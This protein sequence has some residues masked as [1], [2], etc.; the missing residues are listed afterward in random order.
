MNTTN[1]N[2]RTHACTHALWCTIIYQEAEPSHAQTSK[3]TGTHK[4][5]HTYKKGTHTEV[6]IK[7]LMTNQWLNKL[8]LKLFQYW[9]RNA[10]AVII[11]QAA[12]KSFGAFHTLGRNTNF[13]LIRSIGSCFQP[14][15]AQGVVLQEGKCGRKSVG[16]VGV[17]RRVWSDGLQKV[18]YLK[19]WLGERHHNKN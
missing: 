7:S 13:Y 9:A 18:C 15:L 16:N 4:H 19:E 5:T 12:L 11:E 2:F 6:T 17:V 10:A 1:A 14:R 8:K 3:L